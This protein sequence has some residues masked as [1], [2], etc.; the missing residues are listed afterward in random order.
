MKFFKRLWGKLDGSLKL[1]IL[2][3]FLLAVLLLPAAPVF[4]QETPDVEFNYYHSRGGIPVYN[5][6]GGMEQY[7]RGFGIWFSDQ[8]GAYVQGEVDIYE[9]SSVRGSVVYGGTGTITGRFNR[10]GLR[11]GLNTI[12]VTAFGTHTIVLPEGVEAVATSGTAT[13]TGSPLELDSGTND[14]PTTG[15]G[16]FT[17]WVELSY[18]TIGNF[19]GYIG[20]GSRA[21]FQLIG[22]TFVGEAEDGGAYTATLT[23]SPVALRPPGE[24]LNI[25]APGTFGVTIPYGIEGVAESG[26]ATLVGSP[27]TLDMG[28]TTVLDTGVTTGTVIINMSVLVGFNV[29][30][31]F[32]INREGFVTQM[33]GRVDGFYIPGGDVYLFNRSFRARY[34]EGS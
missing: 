31:T 26:T 19:M 21:R 23:G 9:A 2:A 20:E 11:E 34:V 6:N 5:M 22:T 30:G 7:F 15:N 10:V 29:S 17:I 32:R 4:A 1:Q 13:V 14:I 3:V 16:D 28:D 12:T 25:S 27:V 8:E 24:L 33:R 18:Q